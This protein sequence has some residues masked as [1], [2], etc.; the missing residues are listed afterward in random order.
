MSGTPDESWDIW[1][2]VLAVPDAEAFMEATLAIDD[3]VETDPIPDCSESGVLGPGRYELIIE[4]PQAE[5]RLQVEALIARLGT[6]AEVI[7]VRRGE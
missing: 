1:S 5:A 4:R 7:E 3:R 6:P 2:F